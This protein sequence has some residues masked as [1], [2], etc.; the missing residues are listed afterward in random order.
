MGVL[1]ARQLWAAEQ[2]QK[3][4]VEDT[5]TQVRNDS[6]RQR[7]HVDLANV[8]LGP[9]LYLLYLSQSR[10]RPLTRVSTQHMLHQRMDQMWTRYD[11]KERS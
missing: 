10:L 1:M 5:I 9:D 8:G 2:H 6:H 3:A 4:E 7:G 11:L